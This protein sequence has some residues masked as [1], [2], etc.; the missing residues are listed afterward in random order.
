M[1]LW[2]VT[3]IS[4]ILNKPL[5]ATTQTWQYFRIII[6][7]NECVKLWTYTGVRVNSVICVITTEG[8]TVYFII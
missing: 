5:N 2:F 1:K 3:G 8:K 6:C 4:Y 7:L